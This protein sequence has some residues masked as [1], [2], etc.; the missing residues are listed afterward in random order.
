[1]FK[2]FVPKCPLQFTCKA[3]E[4]AFLGSQGWPNIR[5]WCRIHPR[6]G[7]DGF[8]GGFRDERSAT[9]DEV[10]GRREVRTNIRD[11]ADHL[12]V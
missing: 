12:V 1:M 6:L 11:N 10:N 7:L 3:L 9:A 8:P 2:E 5:K 4:P